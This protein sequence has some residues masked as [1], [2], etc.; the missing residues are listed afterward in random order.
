[1]Q[2][3]GLHRDSEVL[4]APSLTLS[5]WIPWGQFCKSADVVTTGAGGG[6]GVASI[7]E[8]ARDSPH[9]G[10]GPCTKCPWC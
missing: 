8:E 6:G 10:E 3:K 9:E 4:S 1:M 5:C 2:G 7:P